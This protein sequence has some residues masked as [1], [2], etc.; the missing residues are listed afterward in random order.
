MIED[1]KSTTMLA[2][3]EILTA[4][5]RVKNE[6]A[7]LSE[8]IVKLTRTLFSEDILGL[9]ISRHMRELMREQLCNMQQYAVSLQSRLAIWDKTDEDLYLEDRK[10]Y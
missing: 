9:N 3:E 10:R 4:K 8:K 2:A 1:E 7:E 6:L 5:E